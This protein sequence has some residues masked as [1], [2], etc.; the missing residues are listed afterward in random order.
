MKEQKKDVLIFPGDHI[1]FIEEFEGG[2]NTYILDGSVRSTSLGNKI[3]DLKRRVVKIEKKNS[4]LIPKLGDVVTGYID[5]LFGSMLSM[6]ILFIND[7]YSMSGF[8]AI[9][10]TRIS[11]DGQ[12]HSRRGERGDRRIKYIFRVGDVIR[13]RVFS[14]LNSNVH[15]TIDEKELGVIYSLCYSCGGNTIR[16][17]NGIKCVECGIYEDKKLAIDYGQDSLSVMYDRKNNLI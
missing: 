13:G 14:L 3:L 1:A 8:S 2:K 16:I 5:M 4:P 9:A 17:N 12:G 11:F 6:R 7:V 15:I 10:S